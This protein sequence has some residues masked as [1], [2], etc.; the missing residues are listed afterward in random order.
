MSRKILYILVSISLVFFVIS[1]L[2]YLRT[3]RDLKKGDVVTFDINNEEIEEL[4]EFRKVT[5][6][7]LDERSPYFY[8]VEREMEVLPYKEDLYRQFL[9]QM[10][11]KEEG[12]LK[13]VP[14]DLRLRSLFFLKHKGILVLDFSEELVSRFPS[15]TR[16]ELEFIYYIVNNLCFNFEE[17]K[18]VK[19]L[20]SG[21]EYRVLS[22][23]LN[24]ENPFLPDFS[25]LKSS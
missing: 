22:G 4:I 1:L 20:V 7:F 18:K 2:V 17:V 5:F 16:S 8:P 21:N 14:P 6:Y 19:F 13:P 24:L 10:F 12:I 9:E 15:G 3:N 11:T 23:H 25:Y